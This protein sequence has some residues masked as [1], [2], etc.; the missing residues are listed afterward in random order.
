ME[1]K[2]GIQFKALDP[3]WLQARGKGYCSQLGKTLRQADCLHGE[4][5]IASG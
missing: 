2:T 4:A 5:T 1:I 3:Y